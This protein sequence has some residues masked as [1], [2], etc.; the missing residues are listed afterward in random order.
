MDKTKLN[1]Y[2]RLLGNQTGLKFNGLPADGDF[3]F[4]D[5]KFVVKILH[6]ALFP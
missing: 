2:I 3:H 4:L 6:A 1:N 5:I